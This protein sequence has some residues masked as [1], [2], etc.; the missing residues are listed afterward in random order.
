MESLAQY[1]RQEAEVLDSAVARLG[2]SASDQSMLDN[3]SLAIFLL[4]FSPLP[5]GLP[6]Y[7]SLPSSVF[8]SLPGPLYPAHSSV[9]RT[10]TKLYYL[11][12][13]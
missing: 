4:A 9:T 7:G 10:V 12:H 3:T 2:N 1:R 5:L 8:L 13:F 11:K 6:G